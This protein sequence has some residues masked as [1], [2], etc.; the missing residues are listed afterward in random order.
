MGLCGRI[1]P[2]IGGSKLRKNIKEIVPGIRISLTGKVEESMINVLD[3][4]LDKLWVDDKWN[5]TGTILLTSHGGSVG[6]GEA[7]A[8]RIEFAHKMGANLRIIGATYVSSAAV[9]ILLS[10]PKDRRFVTSDCV[11]MIHPSKKSID[12]FSSALTLVE[13]IERLNEEIAH[14]KHALALESA[15]VKRLIEV[16]GIERDQLLKLYSTSHRFS[17]RDAIK[18]NLASAIIG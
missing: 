1:V 16:T 4:A 17:A 2:A 6:A 5:K 15:M 13:L 10:L 18:Y 7:V 12:N 11:V 14:A 8:K 9:R 3:E